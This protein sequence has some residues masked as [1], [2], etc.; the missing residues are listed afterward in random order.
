VATAERRWPAWKVCYFVGM[1]A[2][3]GLVVLVFVLGPLVRF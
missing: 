2:L 1:A 3:F